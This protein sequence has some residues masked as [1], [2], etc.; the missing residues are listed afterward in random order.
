MK[1]ISVLHVDNEESILNITKIFLEKTGKVRIDTVT[2]P[3]DAL[4]ILEEESFD[5]LISDYE[6][7][8][9]NGLELLEEVRK[10]CEGLP[11]IIFTGKGREDVV[12]RAFDLGADFYLQKGGD[13]KAQFAELAHKINR[14]PEKAGRHCAS[15][16]RGEILE[17]VRAQS[18]LHG[19]RGIGKEPD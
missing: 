9:M 16:K 17:S 10:T 14:A 11:F 3:H 12:I 18:D 15:F 7:P 8:A 4:K 1:M 19:H 13:P 6:M 2:S 5:A